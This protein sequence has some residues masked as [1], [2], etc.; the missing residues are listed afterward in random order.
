MIPLGGSGAASCGL[1]FPAAR[2]IS[3]VTSYVPMSEEV[4][5]QQKSQSSIFVSWGTSPTAP[6]VYLR[7]LTFYGAGTGQLLRFPRGID[8]PADSSFVL[9]NILNYGPNYDYHRIVIDE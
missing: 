1:G 2:G 3:P 9:F 7:R 5:F 4:G 6:T 8:I